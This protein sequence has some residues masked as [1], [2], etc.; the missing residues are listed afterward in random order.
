M[1]EMEGS[2]IDISVRSCYTAKRLGPKCQGQRD[3]KWV[4]VDKLDE[5]NAELFSRLSTRAA[6]SL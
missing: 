6:S 2:P 3:I 5:T 4:G 1:Q